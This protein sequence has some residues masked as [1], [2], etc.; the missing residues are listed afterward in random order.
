MADME[1]GD[2]MF[3][4]LVIKKK[5]TPV[6]IVLKV[7]YHRKNFFDNKRKEFRLE[8]P[9]GHNQWQQK[10]YKLAERLNPG[11]ELYVDS[12]GKEWCDPIF[13]NTLQRKWNL[14]YL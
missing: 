3:R 9:L 13:H 2:P 11:D 10:W 12:C 1:A 7:R 4:A 14:K 5:I 6:A 8:V